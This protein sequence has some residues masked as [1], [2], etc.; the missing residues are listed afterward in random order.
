MLACVW[1]VVKPRF[2]VKPTNMTAYEGH[3]LMMHC[4]AIGDPLPTILW[5]KNDKVDVLD[6]RRFKVIWSPMQYID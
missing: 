5:D 6:F 1:F 3:S 4:V 2:I